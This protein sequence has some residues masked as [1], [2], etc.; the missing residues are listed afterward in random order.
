MREH[1]VHWNENIVSEVHWAVKHVI[2][3]VLNLG[4]VVVGSAKIVLDFLH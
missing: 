4:L 3:A 2:L 1:G